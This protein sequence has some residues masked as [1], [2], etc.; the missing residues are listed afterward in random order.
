MIQQLLLINI[1]LLQNDS[2]E[3]VISVNSQIGISELIY[4]WNSDASQ[5][6]YE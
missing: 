6:I 3:V 5:T 1:Q 2:G 4:N